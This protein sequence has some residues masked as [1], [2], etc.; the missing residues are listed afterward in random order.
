MHSVRVVLENGITALVKRAALLRQPT[1]NDFPIPFEIPSLISQG[2]SDSSSWERGGLYANVFIKYRT[3]KLGQLSGQLVSSHHLNSVLSEPL[4][5]LHSESEAN[6]PQD[7]RRAA[8]LSLFFVA[9]HAINAIPLHRG[10]V[11]NA[12]GANQ[13]NARISK[14]SRGQF[15]GSLDAKEPCE[16]RAHWLVQDVACKRWEG[17]YKN[18]ARSAQHIKALMSYFSVS[19]RY[20]WFA[21]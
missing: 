11:D 1:H 17:R 14:S 12:V 4:L 6:R 20:P 15:R 18:D 8:L 13:G 21:P 5:H 3:Q 9:G 10:K 7:I 2:A 19:I 16:P